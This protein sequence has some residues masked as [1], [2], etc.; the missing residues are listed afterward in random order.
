MH[1]ALHAVC[2]SVFRCVRVRRTFP[3]TRS[4]RRTPHVYSGADKLGRR[5]NGGLHLHAC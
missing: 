4:V 1:R 5:P 2:M 3:R